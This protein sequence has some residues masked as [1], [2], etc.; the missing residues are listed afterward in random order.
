MVLFTQTYNHIVKTTG[1]DPVFITQ[2]RIRKP[3]LS[4]LEHQFHPF[5]YIISFLQYLFNHY[6]SHSPILYFCKNLITFSK[7]WC[8]LHTSSISISS[9]IVFIDCINLSLLKFANSLP[10][11][12]S[13][14]SLIIANS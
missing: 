14:Q 11:Q 10:N 4:A 9:I 6:I 5:L 13:I 12:S 2:Y 7:D 1:R 3:T 8:S